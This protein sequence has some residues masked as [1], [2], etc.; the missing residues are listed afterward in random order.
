M[1]QNISDTGNNCIRIIGPD[2]IIRTIAGNGVPDFSGDGGPAKSA[3]LNAPAGLAVDSAG[4]I[5]VADVG[6]N[7]VR[8]LTLGQSRSSAG[9]TD[10]CAG[11][12]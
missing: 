11:A 7:R 2:G 4:N 12:I 10:Q 1:S 6:N 9:P 8:K 5:W 3:S